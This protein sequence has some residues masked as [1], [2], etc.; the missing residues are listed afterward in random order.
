MP[1]ERLSLRHALIS[2][3]TAALLWELARHLLGWYQIYLSQAS[4]VYGALTTAVVVTLSL[5]LAAT[6]LLFGA[7]VIA[8][9]ELV[10][11]SAA[12]EPAMKETA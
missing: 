5:E 7:Q 1:V 10:T 3:V 8:Q 9:Y 2:G 11:G 6:L 4:V 12:E